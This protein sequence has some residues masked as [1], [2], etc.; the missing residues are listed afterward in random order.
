MCLIQPQKL[1][2]SNSSKSV[3]ALNGTTH[4]YRFSLIAESAT[5]KVAQFLLLLKLIYCKKTF[6]FI[7]K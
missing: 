5:E 7:K 4:L 6:V 2:C 1:W 3:S